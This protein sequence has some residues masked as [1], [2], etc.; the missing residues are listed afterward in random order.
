MPSFS[1]GLENSLH[2]ALSIARDKKHEF[3]TLEHL[4]LAILEDED[5]TDVF[6]YCS[7]DIDILRD[8]IQGYLDN[9]LRHIIIK[10]SDD[11][12][13]TTSFQRVIQRAVIHVQTSNK[14]VD[15]TSANV[16]V[17]IFSERE[18]HAVYF[19]NKVNLSRYDVVNYLSHG[20]IKKEEDEENKLQHKNHL[21]MLVRAKLQI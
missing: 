11:V 15:V 20:I 4:L 6:K 17:A 19:L 10:D 9:E 12:K 3:S 14:D 16:L 18:S 1:K 21:M 8:E 13:P 5:A 7:I 2:K